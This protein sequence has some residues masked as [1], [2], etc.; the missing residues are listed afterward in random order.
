MYVRPPDDVK[1]EG[2]IWKLLKPLY[3]LDDVSRKFYLKVK[4]TLKELG[5]KTLPGDDAFYYENRD[6]NLLGVNLSHVD[7]FTIAGEEEFV[8]RIVKGISEKF[9]VSKVEENEFRFT[10]LDV[11]AEKGKIEV[12]MEDYAKSVEPI[13]EI[14]KADRKL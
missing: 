6:G 13:E 3:G 8:K 5:L 2:K 14:R 10:G 12:S 11:K 9:T 1:K 7:D 4:E